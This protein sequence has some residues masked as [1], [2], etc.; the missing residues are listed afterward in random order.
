MERTDQPAGRT[1]DVINGSCRF[2]ED[3]ISDVRDPFTRQV[4]ATIGLL[5]PLPVPFALAPVL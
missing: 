4:G 3:E 2:L 5:I 1:L